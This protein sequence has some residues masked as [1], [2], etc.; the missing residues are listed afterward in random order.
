MKK[1]LPVLGV[2]LLLPL[3]FMQNNELKTFESKISSV[4]D[5]YFD[6]LGGVIPSDKLFYIPVYKLKEKEFSVKKSEGDLDGLNYA[7][8]MSFSTEQGSM[9]FDCN[10]YDNSHGLRCHYLRFIAGEDVKTVID[11][12]REVKIDDFK[13]FSL[14]FG[15]L[16][17]LTFSDTG[18][19]Y[20]LPVLC[21]E[22]A[23]FLETNEPVTVCDKFFDAVLNNI[24][25]NDVS[26]LRL[27]SD[28]EIT[29]ADDFFCYYRAYASLNAKGV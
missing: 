13:S 18:E 29:S 21:S 20:S 6:Q 5:T 26:S 11:N 14:Y 17:L 10:T 9:D 2:F 8:H 27:I 16:E 22:Y 7:Y 25:T 3:F 1:Y 23:S 19:S 4:G 15:Y 12:I 24:C 28:L